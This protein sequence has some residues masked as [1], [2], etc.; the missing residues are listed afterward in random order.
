MCQTVRL[1]QA[2][3]TLNKSPIGSVRRSICATVTVR[4][5]AARK[6]LQGVGRTTHHRW[7]LAALA[8]DHGLPGVDGCGVGRCG[9]FR[10]VRANRIVRGRCHRDDWGRAVDSQGLP[11][12]L[13]SLGLVL[14]AFSAAQAEIAGRLRERTRRLR[15]S[16][17]DRTCLALGSDRGEAVYTADC[18][19]QHLNLG[20]RVEAIRS[21]EP[22]AI[23]VETRRSCSYVAS[24]CIPER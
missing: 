15:F 6:L 24:I 4:P 19:L 11:E 3:R 10:N 8:I 9:K 13:A 18:A 1:R 23:P 17:C 21:R 16:L 2:S 12:D 7:H 5:T 14:E 22:V 20:V